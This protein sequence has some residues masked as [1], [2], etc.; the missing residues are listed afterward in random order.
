MQF[1]QIHLG[2]ITPA[3]AAHHQICN[4][5][6]ILL[7]QHQDTASFDALYIADLHKNLLGRYILR[8]LTLL[9][10]LDSRRRDIYRLP[11]QHTECRGR[12]AQTN[13]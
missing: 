8:V 1:A 7:F 3:V 5:L 4:R 9:Y 13:I 11:H 6:G 12:R 10:N 2:K